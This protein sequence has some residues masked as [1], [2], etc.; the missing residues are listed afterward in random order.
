M[1]RTISRR[2]TLQV[3]GV[4]VAAASLPRWAFGQQGPQDSR[5][6]AAD[7][8]GRLA[9]YMAEA[10][11]RALPARVE[12]AAKHRILDTLSAIVSGARLKPG[13]LTIE[14]VRALGGTAEA[15]VA[16]TSIVTTAVNAAF[17]N[18]MFAHAD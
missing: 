14:Y 1:K 3:T 17:A 10:T 7:L 4:M 11:T 18:G 13:E 8:T 15:C 6:R 5:A 12:L 2:R 16:T 9:R